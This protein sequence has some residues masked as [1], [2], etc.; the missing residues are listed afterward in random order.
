MEVMD[1]MFFKNPFTSIIYGPSGSGKSTFVLR[2]LMNITDMCS[3]RVKNI[4]FYFFY[5]NYQKNFQK[6]NI[7]NLEYR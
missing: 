3:Q 5:N 6:E 1:P 4:L 2:V 7:P